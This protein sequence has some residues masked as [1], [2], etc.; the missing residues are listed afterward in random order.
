[1]LDKDDIIDQMERGFRGEAWHGPSLMEALDGV[2][3]ATAN[4]R[5]VD[6]AHTIWELV[7][8]VTVWKRAVG[9]RMK[10]QIAQP[11]G[12]DDFPRVEARGEEDWRAALACLRQSHDDMVATLRA[13]PPERLSDIVPGKDYAFAHMML[14]TVQHDCYHAGQIS[15]LKKG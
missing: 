8:H 12:A 13:A 6:N 9:Q 2:N 4:K 14:G 5:S 1:M 15:L 7:L 10:G 11:A 3:A